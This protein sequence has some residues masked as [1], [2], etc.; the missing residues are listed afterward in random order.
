MDTTSTALDVER[1]CWFVGVLRHTGEAPVLDVWQHALGRLLIPPG[2]C[3]ILAMNRLQLVVL[4]PARFARHGSTIGATTSANGA[5]RDVACSPRAPSLRPVR[6]LLIPLLVL[7]ACA[8]T[9]ESSSATSPTSA[10][11]PAPVPETSAPAGSGSP[12]TDATEP[13]LTTS[14]TTS[15]TTVD[16][17]AVFPAGFD[18]VAARVTEPDGTVC[19]LCLWL[20]ESGSQ[21]SRGLM[22]VTDLG[23]GDGMAFRYSEPHATNFYMQDTLLPLSIAFYGP[24]GS[25]MDSFDMEPCVTRACQRYPTPPDFLIAIETYQGELASIGMIT[26]STLEL[27]DL[28]CGA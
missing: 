12:E 9:D 15:P 16:P 3:H 22:G 17:N 28:P 11:Q 10:P 5:C 19:E 21:R 7:A 2:R 23:P 24:D 1:S 14:S 13:S 4:G 27:L 6:Q 25:F 8:G 26:G 20:A 18:L